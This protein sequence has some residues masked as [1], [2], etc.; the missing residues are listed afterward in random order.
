[1]VRSLAADIGVRDV[2]AVGNRVRGAEDVAY[3]R[4]ALGDIEL[5]GTLPDSDAVRRADREG[6][7][8]FG[9][10]PEFTEALRDDR[11]TRSSHVPAA[12]DYQEETT[13]SSS[14]RRST[15]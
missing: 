1:M 2:V 6:I 15:S 5:L 11:G 13:C 3:L 8:P 4:E 12:A 10:D 9:I 14:V 7:S